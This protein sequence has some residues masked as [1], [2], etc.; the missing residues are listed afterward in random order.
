MK[1]FSLPRYLQAIMAVIML[2]GFLSVSAED[3]SAQI[4]SENFE[5]TFPPSG[6]SV[7]EDDPSYSYVVWHRNDQAPTYGASQ[8]SPI[9]GFHAYAESYPAFCGYSYD[10][11]LVTPPFSTMGMTNIELQFYYQYWVYSSDFLALDYRIGAGP[12]IHLEN[13]PSTGGYT[14]SSRVVDISVTSGNPSVQLRWRYYN[15]G[16]GCDWWTNIDNVV[17][18]NTS[19]VAVPTLTQW[20]MIIF[21]L[22]AGLV[23]VYYLRRQSRAQR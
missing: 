17:I 3:A 1:K 5:G 19:K 18:L 2:L 15:T 4:I 9:S 7:T 11:S 16:S 21:I 6:W 14:A 10:T 13:L 23:A 20:G 12:W 8:S 22:L